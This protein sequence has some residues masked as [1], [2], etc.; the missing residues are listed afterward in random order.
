MHIGE[1]AHFEH[2]S[3]SAELEE[4][5]TGLAVGGA[6]H[7]SSGRW[8]LRWDDGETI[9][10]DGATGLGGCSRGY[11]FNLDGMDGFGSVAVKGYGCP[12]P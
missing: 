6:G 2:V 9:V 3:A 5:A 7:R 11:D 12:R 4:L 1:E 10:F 8:V